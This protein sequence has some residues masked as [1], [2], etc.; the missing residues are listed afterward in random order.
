[1][2]Q[3]ASGCIEG[4]KV[5]L[6]LPL[7]YMNRSGLAVAKF[8]KKFHIARSRLLVISD[9]A[10]LPLGSHRYRE[11]GSSGGHNGLKSIEEALGTQEYPRLRVGIG[12]PLGHQPLADFVLKK[13]S[14]E[15]E[16]IILNHLDQLLNIM[17][18]FVKKGGHTL[19]CS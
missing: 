18:I 4:K 8:L 13:F 19:N 2:A 11:R 15:E 5:I 14:K 9:D 12:Q 1:L 6:L 3:V 10:A 16:E 17:D 7:T